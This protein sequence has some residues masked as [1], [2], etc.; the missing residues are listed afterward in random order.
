[1]AKN[2]F[3]KSVAV[4]PATVNLPATPEA[5]AEMGF[6]PAENLSGETPDIPLIKVLPQAQMFTMPDD[7]KIDVIEGIILLTHRC[8]AWWDRENEQEGNR[9]AC[10]S[11]DDVKPLASSPKVQSA[12]CATCPL[13]QFGSDVGENGARGK[14]KACKNMRRIYILMDGHE[15][16]YLISLSPTS[17]KAAKRYLTQ[18][19]DRKRHVA[20]VFT[21]I[22]L[23]KQTSGS[24][25]YSVAE[26]EAIK[27]IDDLAT[28]TTIAKLRK[29]V[30]QI[31]RGQAI[32]GAEYENGTRDEDPFGD[33]PGSNG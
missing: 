9:P 24:N 16:P 8:N 23:D 32:T 10:S 3:N 33:E 27:D 2:L 7:R 17:L 12:Q 5:L 26:F 31:A 1:M 28:L 22:T 11:L 13:N 20:T 6:D 19:A 15:F 14:G 4:E 21:R 29:Q 25:V 30:E 18:L